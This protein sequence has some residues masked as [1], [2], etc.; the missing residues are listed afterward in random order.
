ME[1]VGLCAQRSLL[2]GPPRDPLG[3]RRSVLARL[4]QLPRLMAV[5]GVRRGRSAQLRREPTI[6]PEVCGA[7]LDSARMMWWTPSVAWKEP[8]T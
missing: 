4:Q 3:R 5:T 7:S 6:A 1:S 8:R 2:P